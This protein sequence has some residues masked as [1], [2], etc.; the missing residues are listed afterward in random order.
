ME[1]MVKPAAA[2]TKTGVISVCAT[3]RTLSSRRYKWLKDRYAKDVK[4]LEPDCGDWAT[5]IEN[6]RLDREKVAKIINDSIESGADQIVLG[7]THYHWIEED[8]KKIARDRA[9]VIQ[10]EKPAIDQLKRVLGQLP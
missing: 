4:V 3:P 2:A 8:I 9:E 6:N 10:P 7:C 1:P 5:M